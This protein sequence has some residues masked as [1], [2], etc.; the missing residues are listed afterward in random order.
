MPERVAKFEKVSKEQFAADFVSCIGGNAAAAERLYE[1]VKLPVRAT[2]GSAGYDIISPV[3]F[4]LEPGQS[5][6]VPTGLRIKMEP[7]WM[8]LILPKSG[9]GSRFRL[10]LDNTMGLIDAD[11][12][13]SDNEG[14]I[15]VPVTNDSK[16]YGKTLTLPAGKA[17]VQAVLVP[18]GITVDDAAGGRRTGGFG[19]TGV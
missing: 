17:F 2:A 12:Y 5:I 6:K 14:H 4:V 19:S 10:Q 18:Y 7:G 1:N 8:L 15:M 11:Y 9:L 16:L 3:D 13:D